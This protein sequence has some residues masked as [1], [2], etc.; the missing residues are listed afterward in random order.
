MRAFA[1]KYFALAAVDSDGVSYRETLEGL[2]A[3]ARSPDRRAA[4]VDELT[5]P[6]FPL[7]LDYLWSIFLRLRRR[8]GSN[9]FAV[10]PI[11]YADIAAFCRLSHMRLSP[12]DTEIIEML[13]N[14]FLIQ[15]NHHVKAET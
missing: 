10:S 5:C 2:I 13:D 12:W 11:E 9:G 15:N 6:P 1:E 7:S 3:R 14:L 4:Y 8:K